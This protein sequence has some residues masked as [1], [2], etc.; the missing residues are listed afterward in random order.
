MSK[1]KYKEGD[2]VVIKPWGLM[3]QEYGLDEDGDINTGSSFNASMEKELAETDRTTTIESATDNDYAAKLKTSWD[4][5]DDMI[6]GH[7]FKWGEE[8]EVRDGEKQDWVK[9]LFCAYLPGVTLPV[10]CLRGDGHYARYEHARPIRKPE[11][12]ITV[13]RDGKELTVSEL[14]KLTVEQIKEGLSHG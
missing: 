11:I 3:E 7:A 5:T 9:E 4:F 12:E 8:I 1:L 14:A 6:L 2:K 13:K 10:V